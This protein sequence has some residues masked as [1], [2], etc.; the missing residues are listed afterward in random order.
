LGEA[1]ALYRGDLLAD[2]GLAEW[3]L[4][5]RE[6][7][8]LV[9]ADAAQGLAELHLEADD[10]EAT[11]EV[12]ERGLGIDRYND[13][14]WRVTIEAHRRSGNRAAAARSARQYRFVLDELGVAPALVAQS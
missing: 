8:R 12:A 7:F 3:V 11:L 6:R 13:R 4:D 1:L 5:E 14:L 2:E 9:A 10:I